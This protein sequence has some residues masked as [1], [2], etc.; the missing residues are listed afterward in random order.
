[1]AVFMDVGGT[2]KQMKRSEKVSTCTSDTQ[3]VGA[4]S[5]GAHVFLMR[6]WADHIKLA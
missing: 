5:V 3:N 4:V 1:M 2:C 6:T